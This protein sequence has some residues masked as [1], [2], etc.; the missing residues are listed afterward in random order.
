MN[1]ARLMETDPFTARLNDLK[2]DP[3]VFRAA[4]ASHPAG[5][6]VITALDE[7]GPMGLTATSFVSI[8]LDPPLVGFLVDRKS[9]TWVRLQNAKTLIVHLLAEDHDT[10]A[11]T[12]ATKSIDR[13]GAPTNWASLTT[14]EPLLTDCTTWMRCETQEHVTLGDHYLV[15]GRVVDACID[16]ER[17]PLLYHQRG[18]RSVRE[19]LS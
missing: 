12:F 15:V 17:A 9:S 19:H 8:S 10:L 18:Y 3:D 11:S 2:V 16:G 4:L 7:E 6:V 13:F 14:G 1:L 5:V